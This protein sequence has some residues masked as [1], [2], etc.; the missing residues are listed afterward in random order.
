MFQT[1]NRWMVHQQTELEDTTVSGVFPAMGDSP[2]P[3][4]VEGAWTRTLSRVQ[5]AVKGAWT[6]LHIA[7]AGCCGGRLDP[8]SCQRECQREGRM[9]EWNI[10][11]MSDSA[12]KYV[13]I[14]ARKKAK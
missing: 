4:A 13:R 5:D 7:S 2:A 3:D 9:S 14:D 8:K 1:I 10:K 6:E 12:R 11:Y